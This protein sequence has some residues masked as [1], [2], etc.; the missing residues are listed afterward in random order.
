MVTPGWQVHPNIYLLTT[1]T[2]G[3]S[4]VAH[5]GPTP[6]HKLFFWAFATVEPFCL[7]TPRTKGLFGLVPKAPQYAKFFCLN[8][9]LQFE[10]LSLGTLWRLR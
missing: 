10:R 5:N 2:G 4:G 8:L 9:V 3:T 6:Y 7:G 1:L